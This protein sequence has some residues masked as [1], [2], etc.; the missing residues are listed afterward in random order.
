[1][2][3]Q[4]YLEMKY[5]PW[6]PDPEG[7]GLVVRESSYKT[8]SPLGMIVVVERHTVR[9]M[10]GTV[11]VMQTRRVGAFWGWSRWCTRWGA[12]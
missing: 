6:A 1:M 10:P 8:K 9:C 4:K 5:T 7:R 12:R 2:P 3:L 11:A